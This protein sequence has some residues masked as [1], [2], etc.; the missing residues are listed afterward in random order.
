MQTNLLVVYVWLELQLIKRI[1]KKT[2]TV[3]E[4]KPRF[5][6]DSHPFETV[7]EK[8]KPLKK[9][10]VYRYPRASIGD[11]T[12]I[13]SKRTLVLTLQ[14]CLFFIATTTKTTPTGRLGTSSFVQV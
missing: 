6:G 13:K 1:R 11:D 4:R 2:Y 7:S 14:S 8:L 5:R 12:L 9:F 10:V 3:V